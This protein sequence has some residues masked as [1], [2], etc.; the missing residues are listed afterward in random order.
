MTMLAVTLV[1]VFKGSIAKETERAT[2]AST[3]RKDKG[4][5]CFIAYEYIVLCGPTFVMLV[6]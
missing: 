2:D 4:V 1:D 3:S 5:F 6:D